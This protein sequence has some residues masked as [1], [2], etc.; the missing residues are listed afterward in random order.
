MQGYFTFAADAR[1]K[2][3]DNDYINRYSF[4]PN[5]KGFESKI[6]ESNDEFAKSCWIAARLGIALVDAFGK[7]EV[8]ISKELA[9][10]A[11]NKF[12]PNSLLWSFF[13][14]SLGVSLGKAAGIEKQSRDSKNK[15]IKITGGDNPF[16]N[17]AISALENHPD[18][19]I[20]RRLYSA[21]LG[22]ANKFDRND[23]VLKYLT[24]FIEEF[25][26]GP[27]SK[28]TIDEYSPSRTMKVN[29]KIPAFE[30]KSAADSTKIVTDK[31]MLG[32]KYLIHVWGSWCAPCVVQ[33]E[34]I[35]NINNRF[36]GKN[37]SVLSVSVCFTKEEMFKFQ[38]THPMPWFN[39]HVD[40]RKEANG[41]M[42]DFEISTVPKDILV[43]ETGE[44]IAV[45]DLDKIL[46]ILS[47]K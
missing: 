33:L 15:T 31:N 27:F 41:F 9:Q 22:L 44:I 4:E 18:S 20:R 14:S 46:S 32:R 35:R 23:L 6:K 43:D 29:N 3:F 5:M 34:A 11:L 16:I 17:Y 10:E 25:G 19:T 40:M 28:S 42:K 39:S 47:G 36:S 8:K 37:F 38:K 13:A 21:V 45:N 1:K 24:K 30:L 2:G 12:E 26:N 7:K